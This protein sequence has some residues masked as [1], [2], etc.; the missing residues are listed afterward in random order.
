MALGF[1]LAIAAAWLGLVGL[2]AWR[3]DQCP[4]RQAELTRKVVHIGTGNVILIAW[5]LD[6]P[7]WVGIA[8]SFFF[9]CI[10]L[11]SYLLPLL[12]GINS[13]GRRSF[14]TFFYA[15]TI[16]LLVAWF[17]PLSQPQFAALGVLIMTWGDGLAGLVGRAW[18]RH[19]YELAGMKK[20]W[21]G[22]LTMASVSGLIT[23]IILGGM[24]VSP[25]PSLLGLALAIG[26]VSALL[27]S[28]SP[29]GID[30]LTVPLGSA[31]MA[32]FVC[33]RLF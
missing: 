16:G 21:E 8:A 6:I 10:A 24:G 22:S 12:P 13:V 4:Q 2:V 20:S 11:L 26:V 28:F 27:E 14:G 23:L 3:L 18:G 25:W 29:W 31:G 5:V 15:V 19:G 32:W 30:N 33:E 9:G 17:W 1:K 7:T